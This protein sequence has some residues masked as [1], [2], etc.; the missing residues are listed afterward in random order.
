MRRLKTSML[1]ALKLQS[2][3]EANRLQQASSL[4]APVGRIRLLLFKTPPTPQ[5]K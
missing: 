2:G 4:Q 5:R 1:A 3:A